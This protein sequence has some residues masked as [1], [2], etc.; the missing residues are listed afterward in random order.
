MVLKHSVIK[1]GLDR[2]DHHIPD[3]RAGGCCELRNV[4]L[5]PA[6]EQAVQH[7]AGDQAV[8]PLG[9]QGNEGFLRP[10]AGQIKEKAP[11][12]SR[13]EPM[14][15]SQKDARQSAQDIG[16]REGRYP[17]QGHRHRDPQKIAH[18]NDGRHHCGGRQLYQQL[19]CLTLIHN[20]SSLG[21]L[22][23]SGD[24]AIILL[25]GSIETAR[26]EIFYRFSWEEG[27][28]LI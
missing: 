14:Q 17:A 12:P 22:T 4:L 19:M 26:I 21:P 3:C 10:N 18:K 23:G 27:R 13:Q 15:R 1:I 8:H 6:S 16:Q 9:T 25:S 20:V 5:L 7:Q 24:T 11:Q 28:C 2:I